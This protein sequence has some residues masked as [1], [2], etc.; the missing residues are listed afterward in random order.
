MAFTI[1]GKFEG[2]SVSCTWDNGKITASEDWALAHLE[3]ELESMKELGQK[4]WTPARTFS[5][6]E[7]FLQDPRNALAL[8]EYCLDVYTSESGDV[9]EVDPDPGNGFL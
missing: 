2:E 9:P 5:Y 6:S 1:H 8:I 4:I 3:A 7:N